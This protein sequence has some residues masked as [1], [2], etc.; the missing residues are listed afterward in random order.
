M[1]AAVNQPTRTEQEHVF[2][3]GPNDGFNAFCFAAC[4]R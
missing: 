4:F 3:S 1:L 2:V